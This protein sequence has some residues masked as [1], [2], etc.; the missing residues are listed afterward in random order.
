MV[1]QEG[2]CEMLL[3]Q[4]EERLGILTWSSREPL[5]RHEQ[6]TTVAA[7]QEII[8]GGLDPWAP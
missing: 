6:A 7:K 8:I 1:L 5:R 4:G 3:W 2:F